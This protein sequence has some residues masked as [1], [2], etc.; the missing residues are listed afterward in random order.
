MK[1][2]KRHLL[3]RSIATA[4]PPEPKPAPRNISRA[5]SNTQPA[6]SATLP[7]PLLDLLLILPPLLDSEHA[8]SPESTALLLS[9]PPLSDLET[10]LPELTSLV[11]S[12]LQASALD[13]ARISHPSTNPSYLHR[14]IASLSQSHSDLRA[15]AASAQQSLTTARLSTLTALV[16][17]LQTY[18]QCNVLLTR[19]LEAKHGVVARSLELRA[20]DISTQAQRAAIDAEQTMWS[21]R[22]DVYPPRVVAALRN[23][24]AHLKDARIRASE[25]IRGLNAEL[26]E[27]GVDIQGG[28]G[29]E[30][31]MRE[32]ARVYR[33]MGRQ[34]GDVKGD[35]RRLQDG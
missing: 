22:R 2:A 28:E 29:K 34:M 20:A 30:K 5:R 19:S 12:T 24:T 11:S 21:L 8:L 33:D 6:A 13:L 3:T 31:V 9:T 15:A 26:A 18:S 25:R 32:M 1:T 23:Y 14:H 7:E 4:T 27:Y 16:D 17:L 35:L 10:L